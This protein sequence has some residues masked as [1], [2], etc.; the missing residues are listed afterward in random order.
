MVGY[1]AEA[2]PG[3]NETAVALGRHLGRQC[4][5]EFGVG[6]IDWRFEE[7]ALWTIQ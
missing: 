7:D 5:E 4:G 2:A 1:V 3:N 6:A